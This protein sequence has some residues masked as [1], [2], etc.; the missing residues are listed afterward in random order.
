MLQIALCALLNSDRLF[1]RPPWLFHRRTRIRVFHSPLLFRRVVNLQNGNALV[2][3]RETLPVDTIRLLILRD[4]RNLFRWIPRIL[5][6]RP[7]RPAFPRVD[8][9]RLD[10]FALAL[11]EE[12]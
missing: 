12:F 7:R 3:V 2:V 8:H 9:L 11:G 5:P 1:F 4:P 10:Q 6:Q